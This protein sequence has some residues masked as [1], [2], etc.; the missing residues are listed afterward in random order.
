MDSQ[1]TMESQQL[2]N[3]T[4]TISTG[5]TKTIV[6]KSMQEEKEQNEK[7][8]KNENIV[9]VENTTKNEITQE[10]VENITDETPMEMKQQQPQT[11]NDN[12]VTPIQTVS[13]ITETKDG[14]KLKFRLENTNVSIANALRRIILSEIP[15]V[16]IRTSPYEKN[17]VKIDVNTTR[18]NNEIIKQ[19]LSCIPIHIKESEFSSINELTLELNVKNETSSLLYVTTGDFKIKNEKTNTYIS[20]EEVKRIFPPDPITNDYIDIVR[21]RPKTSSNGEELKLTC[22]LDIGKSKEDSSFA[23]ASTCCYS[24]VVD[25]EKVDVEWS[26]KKA[27]LEASGISGEE[28]KSAEKNWRLLDAKRI[29]I[30]DA[31]DFVVE[32]VGVFT[33]KSIVVKA[34]KIMIDKL[35]KIREKISS[36]DVINKSNT[37][38]ENC[39]DITLE[40]EDYTLGKVLEYMLYSKHYDRFSPSSDK[41]LNYCG[42]SKPHPH[43]NSSIIRLAFVENVDI[44]EIVSYITRASNDSIRIFEMI[45]KQFY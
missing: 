11:N 38:I 15:T 42:F 14:T 26:L 44:D 6:I 29:T 36:R 18:M 40:G 19:R 22:S 45:S 34:C 31:F 4:K 27:E 35:E 17:R 8:Q 21:L 33:N 24:C 5:P 9:E 25:D 23:V 13:D 10:M 12:S 3:E 20:D 7:N 1:Q 39:Y 37:T 2:S 32:T 43:I 41:T 16:V 30:P 28:L